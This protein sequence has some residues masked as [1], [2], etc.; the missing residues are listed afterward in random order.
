VGPTARILYPASGI[1]LHNDNDSDSTFD[2]ARDKAHDKAWGLPEL[3]NA[4]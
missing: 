4:A 2:K 3:S 1:K